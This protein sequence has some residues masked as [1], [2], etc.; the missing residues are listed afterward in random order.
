[1]ARTY[2]SASITLDPETN[3][4]SVNEQ[5]LSAAVKHWNSVDM[6]SEY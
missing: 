4:P 6:A 3:A 2:Y 5:K 1:M